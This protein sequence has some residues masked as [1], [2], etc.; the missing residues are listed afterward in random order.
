MKSH[1]KN[2]QYIY[3]ITRRDLDFPSRAVQAGHSVFE[4]SQEFR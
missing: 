2:K 4:A 1:D 3:S